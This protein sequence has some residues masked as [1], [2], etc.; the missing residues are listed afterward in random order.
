MKRPPILDEVCHDKALLGATIGCLV[1]TCGWA[2][3]IFHTVVG[4]LAGNQ[5]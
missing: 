2:A 3:L 5:S 1:I 4:L